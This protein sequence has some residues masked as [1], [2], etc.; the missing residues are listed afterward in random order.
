MPTF[1]P[2]RSED[3]DDIIALLLDDDLGQRR[4]TRD[5]TVY[6]AAFDAIE[7]EPQNQIIVGEADGQIVATYQL[8]FISG[9]SH[10]ATRRAQIESVRVAASLRGGGVG[11]HMMADAEARARAAGCR[12]MQLTTH[13]TRNHARDFYD[14]LDFEP[15]H[16][17]YKK[18]L[19]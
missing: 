9:L 14:G 3:L 2:A 16:V 4:E 8:T 13:A 6:R 12:L 19:R 11:R 18:Q 17:G 1:R 15:T 5:L 7:A 10:Q